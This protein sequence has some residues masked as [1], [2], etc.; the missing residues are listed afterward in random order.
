MHTS[1]N[2]ILLVYFIDPLNTPIITTMD[3]S[4]VKVV[5]NIYRINS[6]T[7][8]GPLIVGYEVFRFGVPMIGEYDNA[9]RNK[10]VTISPAVPGAQYR[11]QAWE[12]SNDGRRSAA[13]AV[14]SV[15]ATEASKLTNAL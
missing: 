15:E 14:E 4:K 10:T 6:E 3:P 5:Y 11:I 12:L 2:V 7:E 1:C 9:G 8:A 13:P